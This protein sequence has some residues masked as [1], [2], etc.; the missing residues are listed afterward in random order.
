MGRMRPK[1]SNRAVLND[2]RMS[3]AETSAGIAVTHADVGHACEDVDWFPASL[4]RDSDMRSTSITRASP[5]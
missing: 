4:G 2:A 3:L 1:S 5:T